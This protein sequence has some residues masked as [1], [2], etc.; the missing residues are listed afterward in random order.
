MT[1]VSVIVLCRNQQMN[2]PLILDALGRQRVRPDE[3]IIA[4]DRSEGDIASIA[5]R[6]GC[7]YVSTSAYVDGDRDGL[8]ALARQVGTVSAKHEILAYLDGDIIPSSGFLEIGVAM[9]ALGQLVKAPRRYRIGQSGRRSR[10]QPESL[11][12]TARKH[13][14][15]AD[16]TSDSF[17]VSR[18]AVKAVGGWDERFEGWGEEDVEFAFRYESGGLPIVEVNHPDFFGAHLD[19]PIDHSKNFAS[20]TKNA[21]YFAQKH[22]SVL[23]RRSMH[24]KSLGLYLA[25]YGAR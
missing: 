24:W 15:F 1:P 5:K 19:H 20:L 14:G 13:L 2:L 7:R 25:H 6:F 4:D 9:A 11:A 16:F 3:V 10:C 22:P 12:R 23:E 8:R 21:K 18:S 17:V